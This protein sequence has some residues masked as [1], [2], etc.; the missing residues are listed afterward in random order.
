MTGRSERQSDRQRSNAVRT[1]ICIEVPQFIRE[2]I[3]RLQEALGRH[4]A[5]IS[6]VKPSNIH[7]T[8]K[9]LGDVEA[10]RIPAVCS[11]AERAVRLSSTFDIEVGG[12]GCFPSAKS[13]RVFWVGL[14]AVPNP[15]AQLHG[16]IENEL[17]SEGFPREARRFSPHLTIGR[18]RSPKQASLVAEELIRD[19]F[20]AESF[21]V[22][23]VIVMRSDLNAM[24]S[25]YTPIV[26]LKVGRQ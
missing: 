22:V 13:P 26:K 25:V 14:T 24:G 19:G 3:A 23:E 7:L 15:L 1:F 21:R 20:D 2:R 8:I 17:A 11:A 4:E 9:F 12:A 18:V 10:A 16:S 6:W 5:R